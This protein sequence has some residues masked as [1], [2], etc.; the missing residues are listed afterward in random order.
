MNDELLR[1]A[2]YFLATFLAF[3]LNEWRRSHKA[4]RTQDTVDA[5]WDRRVGALTREIG[6]L[7]RD[8]DEV[9]TIVGADSDNGLRGEIR[10]LR[11]D[12][13]EMQ[14]DALR[15]ARLHGPYRPDGQE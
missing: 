7:R 4:A 11:N 14:R 10:E 15:Q 8:L 2:A 13:K 9:S 1:A 3:G 12:V 5:G 6:E